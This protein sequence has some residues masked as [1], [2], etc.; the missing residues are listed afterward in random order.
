[1]E[2]NEIILQDNDLQ[3]EDENEDDFDD[4]TLE[5]MQAFDG[6]IDEDFGEIS[7]SDKDILLEELY[8]LFDGNILFGGI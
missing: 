8:M 2:N 4:L 7:K 6:D 3:E 1:M 5:E